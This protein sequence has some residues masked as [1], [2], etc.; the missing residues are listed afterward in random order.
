MADTGGFDFHQHL[1]GA[2]TFEIHFNDFEG[3]SSGPG[4]C[5]FGFHK[6]PS[7]ALELTCPV[8]LT[9]GVTLL[10]EA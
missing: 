2:R 4:N 8:A 5:S 1:T 9:S 6:F 10:R 3:L 7:L